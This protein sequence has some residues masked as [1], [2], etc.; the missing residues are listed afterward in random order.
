VSAEYR[1][2]RQRPALTSS[3]FGVGRHAIARKTEPTGVPRSQV[4]HRIFP[5]FLAAC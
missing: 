5:K 1:F 3:A 4:F 2:D